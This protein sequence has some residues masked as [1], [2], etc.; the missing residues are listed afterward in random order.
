MAELEQSDRKR[1]EAAKDGFADSDDPKSPHQQTTQQPR[2]S[3]PAERDTGPGRDDGL[4][5]KDESDET[6]DQPVPPGDPHTESDR[7]D[8]Q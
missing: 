7:T 5:E 8:V 6:S 3:P 2:L 1:G 4:G